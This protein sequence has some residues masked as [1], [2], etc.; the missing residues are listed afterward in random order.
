[1]YDF[2][3]VIIIII[4]YYATKKQNVIYDITKHTDT[5]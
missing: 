5:H 2:K 4:I 3:T 1:M